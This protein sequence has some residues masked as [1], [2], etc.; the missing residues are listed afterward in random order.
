MTAEG[1][2]LQRGRS[3]TLALLLD[4]LDVGELDALRPFPCVAEIELVPRQIDGIAVDIVGD[5]GGVGS[6]EGIE[7]LAVVRRDPARELEL[8][9]L[10]FDWERIFRIQPGLEHVELECANDANQR[11]CAVARAEY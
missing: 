10:E 4:V 5:A 6:D 2:R 3:P 1:K 8:A 11:R 7:L 9:D